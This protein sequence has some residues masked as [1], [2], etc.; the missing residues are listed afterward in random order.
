MLQKTRGIVLH[1]LKYSES[2]IISHV[3]TEKFGRLSLISS[4]FKGKNAKNKI[5][6]FQPL[7]LVEVDVYL[8]QSN[9]VH[10][11]K[12]IKPYVPLYQLSG[13]MVKGAIAIFIAELL[14]KT[15]HEKEP[16]PEMYSFLESAIQYLEHVGEGTPNFHLVFIIQYMK[17]LGI[18]HWPIFMKWKGRIHQEDIKI[19][20]RTVF[21]IFSG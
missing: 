20:G 12:E 10:R 7:S 4:G 9:E 2:S 1:Y 5:I 19:F 8:K 6:Y 21:S 11:I 14:Y 13:N 3:Y 16:N 15:I 17:L 18:F